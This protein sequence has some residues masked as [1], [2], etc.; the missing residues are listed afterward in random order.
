MQRYEH[1]P[2]M[3]I[4]NAVL[5]VFLRNNKINNADFGF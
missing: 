2:V 3:Q 5:V 1:N 4:I